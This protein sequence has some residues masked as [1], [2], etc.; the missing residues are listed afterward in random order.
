[1]RRVK[2]WLA[3]VI[4]MAAVSVGSLMTVV[5]ADAAGYQR[6][7]TVAEEERVQAGYAGETR[8]ETEKVHPNAWKKINGSC[9][10]GS[11]MQIPGAITRGID[12]SEW[13]GIID[14]YKVKEAG[15][16][17]AFVRAYHGTTHPDKNFVYNME[18]AE[19]AGIPAGV[20]VYSTATT[21][22]AALEEAHL[23]IKRMNGYKVSYP[24]VFDLEYPQ[25]GKLTKKQ[26][27]EI[28]RTF[29]EEVKRAG[30]YP[31]VYCNTNWYD[32]EVDW[33]I[34][35]GYDVW[36][37]RYGDRIQAPS[38]SEYKYTVWQATDGDG[39]GT[40]NPT[41]GL[42]P[43][44]PKENN[45]D[46]NFGYVDY[47]KKIVPIRGAVAG[48]EPSKDP[49]GD[50]D[51]EE[52]PVKNG[53]EE[54]GG[55]I[56]YYVNGEKAKGWKR[57]EGKYYYFD[58]ETGAA[59]KGF[60]KIE[61]KTYYFNGKK[62]YAYRKKRIVTKTGNIYYFGSNGARCENG[63]YKVK[64]NGETKTFY[65][66]KNGKAHKGWLT[67]RGKKYYFYNGTSLASGTRAENVTLTSSNKVVSVFDKNGVCI[68]QYRKKA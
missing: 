64:I 40:L 60:K 67:L 61:G 62:G 21:A 29:C 15:I 26:V 50:E 17:F 16:D 31:M 4:C 48:Y 33:S 12:V 11:G 45:V 41:K 53:W 58:T 24:V 14:W 65:F 35:S 54:D 46:I 66:H 36:I 43:G 13:Q 42:V 27:S 44:I 52:K 59:Y 51:D 23:V 32:E 63:L 2:K 9:Y 5:V 37:A 57:I 8:K 49:S 20:Y 47:T 19:Q 7:D 28:A 10:N 34:L 1:M 25:M 22:R 39:G 18:Q 38:H 3:A 6:W 30:Y 55:R 68:K 56:Y